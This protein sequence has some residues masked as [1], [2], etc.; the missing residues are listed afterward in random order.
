MIAVLR[1]L[2]TFLRK[3]DVTTWRAHRRAC[4]AMLPKKEQAAA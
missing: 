4:I 1:T 3:R 2:Y